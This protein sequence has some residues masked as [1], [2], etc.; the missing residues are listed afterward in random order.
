MEPVAKA[1]RYVVG[2]E[3]VDDDDDDNDDD[4]AHGDNSCD[5]INN[6]PRPN[7]QV[8]LAANHWASL[9]FSLSATWVEGEKRRVIL[10]NANTPFARCKICAGFVRGGGVA[11]GS[12]CHVVHKSS[13]WTQSIFLCGPYRCCPPN[14][15]KITYFGVLRALL[16]PPVISARLRC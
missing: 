16:Q 13:H 12:S 7:Y 3:V 9:G 15:R 8:R 1:A 5:R 11:L 4:D 10:R 6:P 2:I 14:C